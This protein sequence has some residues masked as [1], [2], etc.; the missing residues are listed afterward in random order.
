M[1]SGACSAATMPG[2]GAAHPRG[3]LGIGC[4][5]GQGAGQRRRVARRDEQA[6]DAV[7]NDLGHAARRAG[8]DRQAGG[9]RPRAPPAPAARA[10]WRA[11]QA[12]PRPPGRFRRPRGSPAAPAGRGRPAGLPGRPGAPPRRCRP[13][14]RPQPGPRRR[15]WPDRA[16]PGRRQHFVALPVADPADQGHRE[17][18]GRQAQA[19]P[20]GGLL[21]RDGPA[22]EAVAQQHRG[23]RRELV[24]DGLGDAQQ[25]V[26]AE[27]APAHQ[28]PQR[29]FD[30]AA[31]GPDLAY[32]HHVRRPGRARHAAAAQHHRGVVVHHRHRAFAGKLAQHPPVGPDRP[33]QPERAGR[34]GQRPP[35]HGQRV[36]HHLGARLL[37]QRR[38]PAALGQHAD[39][40]PAAGV[41]PAHDGRELHV[42]AVQ[43]RRGVQ[44]QDGSWHGRP[45]YAGEPER[46]R[47]RSSQ[48]NR[49]AGGSGTRPGCSRWAS[50]STPSTSR[51]PGRE[52]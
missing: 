2:P 35:H 48:A 10:A 49:S 24:A 7:A 20:G 25:R 46:S 4:Q 19:A 37:Q 5:P 39:G 45:A 43:A 17:A 18:V 38:Q 9:A 14:R 29:A 13:A 44:Q 22:R 1:R 12:R 36:H 3:G 40:P 32:V 26:G 31:A 41:Q 51:G 52:K 23:L 11:P 8:H 21:D 34:G 30:R 27:Q 50:S 16:P 47:S 33:R 42:G 28:R 15:S 6:R